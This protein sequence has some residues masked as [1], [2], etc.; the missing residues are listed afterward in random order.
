MT[1]LIAFVTGLST[2]GLT[3]LAVQGGLLFGLLVRKG[4][5]GENLPGWQRLLLPVGAFL[6]T[7]V[8]V[9]T[10]LGFGLGWLGGKV[11]LSGTVLLWLQLFA[12]LV[13]V[14]A[15]IRIFFPSWLPWLQVTP[16]AS[17]R[18]FIRRSAKS[19]AMVA[20]AALGVLTLLIPCGT[21]QA[22]EVAA[23]ATGSPAQ[24]ATIML[25]FT[26]GTAPLFIIVGLL[27]KGVN[28]FQTK[29]RY[30]AA[31]LVVG[32]G[33]Y[34]INGVLVAND[35]P[36]AF[37]RQVAA[38]QRVFLGGETVEAGVVA[39]AAPTIE[40]LNAGYDPENVVVLAGRPVS[41]KLKTDGVVSCTSTFRI[42][43]LNIKR[44]LPRTGE[45]IVQAT[46][47]T[48]GRYTFSCGMGM[49]SGTIDAV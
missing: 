7:K 12:G 5:D 46:F 3:C 16:P 43:K 21:T 42:P 8:V 24:A 38:F 4:E 27:A 37:Q 15:G 29:L 19:Q 31:A 22:M 33:F 13:M 36:Y 9:H 35:S 6:V 14:A 30:I 25:A 49:F 47:P 40:V 45:V 18:R 44:T 34:A 11:Q 10:L 23:I 32:L 48:P 26:L 2:G 17:V 20:P 41:L 28:V 1:P 39:D